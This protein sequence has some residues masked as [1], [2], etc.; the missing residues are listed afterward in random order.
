MVGMMT[1][2]SMPLQADAPGAID[3]QSLALF[4]FDPFDP[5][6]GQSLAKSNAMERVL[7]R[8][9]EPN[10]R[11]RPQSV[12]NPDPTVVIDATVLR[13]DGLAIEVHEIPARGESWITRM[14]LTGNGYSIRFNLG[15]GSSRQA[16]RDALQSE[17]VREANDMLLISSGF[18]DQGEAAGERYSVYTNTELKIQFDERDRATR[19][20][21]TH[22]AD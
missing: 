13:Y 4:L 3:R 10:D 15:I 21:W 6:I 11:Y 18:S 12:R 9:G 19:M 16:F 7:K 5:P 20:V 8:F 14:E 1:A 22:Y 17:P 2:C